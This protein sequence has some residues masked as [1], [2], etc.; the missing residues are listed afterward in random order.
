M[1]EYTIESPKHGRTQ[2]PFV[3]DNSMFVFNSIK[4]NGQNSPAGRCRNIQL[5]IKDTGNTQ[6][7][8]VN[9]K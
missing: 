5:I 9:L 6:K 7:D 4:D 3:N 1:I 8:K 2:E